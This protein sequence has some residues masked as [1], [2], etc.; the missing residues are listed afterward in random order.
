[1]KSKIGRDIIEGLPIFTKA[2]LA[3]TDLESMWNFFLEKIYPLNES[4]VKIVEYLKQ[5]PSIEEY[6]C[7]FNIDSYYEKR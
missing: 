5:L 4:D 7:Y 2:D 1:M 6:A 3:H